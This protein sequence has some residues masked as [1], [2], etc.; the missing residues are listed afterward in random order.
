MSSTT[1]DG[2]AEA[3]ALAHV[4]D[5]KELN[6]S[7]GGYA[8]DAAVLGQPIGRYGEGKYGECRSLTKEEI[9]AG[10]DAPGRTFGAEKTEA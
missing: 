6:L 1:N 4:E 5:A 8:G 7:T 2:T 9:A 3:T 10:A